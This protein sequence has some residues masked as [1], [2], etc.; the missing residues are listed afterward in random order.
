MGAGEPHLQPGLPSK[1]YRESRKAPSVGIT[2][3]DITHPP[4]WKA[5]PSPAPT[6][7]SC[8]VEPSNA[9]LLTPTDTGPARPRS[10]QVPTPPGAPHPLSPHF[11]QKA[12]GTRGYTHV[13]S[14]GRSCLGNSPTPAHLNH[15]QWGGLGCPCRTPSPAATALP[16]A[17]SPGPLPP[18]PR[19]PGVRGS[20]GSSSPTRTLTLRASAPET[21]SPAKVGIR[22]EKRKIK[23]NS[24]QPCPLGR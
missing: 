12:R 10:P 5:P 7:L 14:P 17:S 19:S 3:G 20:P 22:E 23:M 13:Q 1:E 18:Q 15:Q 21:S 6:V 11:P 4:S 24:F 2:T 9:L 16:S 8:S